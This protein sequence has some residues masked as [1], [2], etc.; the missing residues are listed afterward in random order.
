MQPRAALYV[1]ML[2]VGIA[3]LLLVLSLLL[4]TAQTPPTIGR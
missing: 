4:S 1:V 2:I 3:A